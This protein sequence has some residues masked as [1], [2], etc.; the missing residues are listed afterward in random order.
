MYVDKRVNNK[1][2]YNNSIYILTF[3]K[4]HTSVENWQDIFLL[5]ISL[6]TF[7]LVFLE[8]TAFYLFIVAFVALFKLV[9]C[10]FG[11]IVVLSSLTLHYVQLYFCKLFYLFFLISKGFLEKC[12]YNS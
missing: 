5:D 8:W 6:Y 1:Y 10:N 3:S 7:K 4:I 9:K 11:L 2:L 12:M